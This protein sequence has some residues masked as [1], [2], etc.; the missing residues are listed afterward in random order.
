MYCDE[1]ERIATGDQKERLRQLIASLG[2]TGNSRDDLFAAL[3][4]DIQHEFSLHRLSN[5]GPDGTDFNVNTDSLYGMLSAL[6]LNDLQFN[7][8]NV[9]NIL[10]STPNSYNLTSCNTSGW[11]VKDL[12]D[13]KIL[14]GWK[15]RGEARQAVHRQYFDVD[16]GRIHTTV[17]DAVAPQLCSYLGSNID[18]DILTAQATG[19]DYDGLDD[20]S[21]TST[22]NAP[23]S[24]PVNNLCAS[25]GATGTSTLGLKDEV[26][27]AD[28][29]GGFRYYYLS[30]SQHS[31]ETYRIVI[32]HGQG[33]ANLYLKID[34]FPNT[35][36]YDVKSVTEGNKECILVEDPDQGTGYIGVEGDYSDVTLRVD[37]WA[38]SCDGF[39]GTGDGGGDDDGGS[40]DGGEDNGGGDDDGNTPVDVPD[41]CAVGGDLASTE[42]T[43]GQAVCLGDT[44]GNDWH[45]VRIEGSPSKITI[46]TDH[47][48]GDLSLY[49]N[50][51]IWATDTNYVSRS[52]ENGNTESIVIN[53]PSAEAI[54][55]ITVVGGSSGASIRVDVE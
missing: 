14:H 22:N 26:C 10:E 23:E 11:S 25:Q 1:E 45:W 53:N 32:D 55:Y 42:L 35:G 12:L 13:Y 8:S 2:G 51:T 17:H 21:N 49:Y 46:R 5:E 41:V 36:N 54:Q 52:T 15:I 38:D 39:V 47:G 20:I 16:V 6:L 18:T 48:N 50:P 30:H 7:D 19:G 44:T 40:D 28:S 3:G 37:Y 33:D 34:G 31:P 27:I 29:N 9:Q 43:N 24:G 4:I